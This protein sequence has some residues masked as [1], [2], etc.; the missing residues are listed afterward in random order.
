MNRKAGNIP[1]VLGGVGDT[2]EFSQR[3]SHDF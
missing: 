2:C 1:L 3:D